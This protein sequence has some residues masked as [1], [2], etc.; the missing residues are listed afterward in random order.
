MNN[1]IKI[2]FNTFLKLEF[3]DNDNSAKKKFIGILVSYLFANTVL[4]FNSFISFEKT[5]YELLAFSTGVFLLVFVVLNDFG[6]IFFTKR[7]ID[8]VNTLP[9]S[10]SELVSA[11]F[12]S[13][14]A[15]LFVYAVIIIIPQT[16]FFF[17]YEKNLVETAFFVVA[18]F[19]SL[20]FILGIIL[21][22]Y[23]I[24]LKLFSGKSGFILYFLQFIF[25]FYVIFISSHIS[26]KAVVRGDIM[27]IGYIKY[28]PQYYFTQSV[29]N[30]TL[31]LVLLIATALVYLL[32]YFYLKNNYFSLSAIIY[33]LKEKVKKDKTKNGLFASYNY[34]ICNR[35]INNNEEKASYLLTFNQLKS[36][37]SLKMK[38]IPLTFIP[39]IVSLI[40]VFSD[41]LTFQPGEKESIALLV[42]SVFFTLLM[43]IKLL[44]SATKI[45][46]ENSTGSAW[47]FSVLPIYSP[48]RILNANI[49]FVFS[50]F[51]IPVAIILFA[52]MIFKVEAFTLACNILFMLSASYFIITLFL[53]FDKIFPYSLESSRYNSVSKFGE[54][55]LIMLVGV[56]IFVSQIFIFENVIFVIISVILFYVISIVLKTKQ[57]TLKSNL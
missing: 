37:K 24:S 46:D 10:K 12:I 43:C 50:N 23:T 5:S 34:F 36:S 38:F 9:I 18:G 44:I 41:N 1:N 51:V 4:S 6:N 40:A 52:L 25:F 33:S 20:F 27:N 55:L 42:P 54:I 39:L 26:K 31:L 7:H 56:V 48:K 17:F 22:L 14:F 2:L 53:L 13:S 15:Y 32:Y 16:I 21:F 29:N 47:M 35:F 3:R 8:A 28:F 57:F 11:K 30:I 49:K 45:E 19:S